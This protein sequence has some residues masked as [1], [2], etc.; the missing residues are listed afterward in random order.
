MVGASETSKQ[1][2]RLKWFLWHDNL[3]CA[4]QVVDDL[5]VGLDTEEACPEQRK[6]LKAVGEFSVYLRANGAWMP[7]YGERHRNGETISSAFVESTVN[8]VVSKRMVKKQQMRWTPRGAH[9]LL[10]IRTTCSTTTWSA[11]SGA[12][13]RPSRTPQEHRAWSRDPPTVCPSLGLEQAE[14]GIHPVPPCPPPL[15][16]PH[17]VTTTR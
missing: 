9:L 2:E 13:T 4:L 7:N 15:P 3:F 5:E 16:N 11:R 14:R 17:P 1:L 12:G 8:Q 6:L 10:Q